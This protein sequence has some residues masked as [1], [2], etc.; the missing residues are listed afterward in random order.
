LTIVKVEQ[1]M[2]TW[3]KKSENFKNKKFN[4]KTDIKW[5]S[6]CFAG[7]DAP[8]DPSTGES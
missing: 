2:L 1:A 4:G 5:T 8:I 3:N 6:I 7:E